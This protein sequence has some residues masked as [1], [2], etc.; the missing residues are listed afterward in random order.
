MEDRGGKKERQE[1]RQRKAK[2]NKRRGERIGIES[3]GEREGG[4]YITSPASTGVCP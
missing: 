1:R 4:V 3:K 2:D